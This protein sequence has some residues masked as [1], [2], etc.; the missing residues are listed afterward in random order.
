MQNPFTTTLSQFIYLFSLFF[1]SS[2]TFAS[3]TVFPEPLTPVI[4]YTDSDG[5]SYT[6]FSNISSVFLAVYRYIPEFC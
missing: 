1:N 2:S 4:L 5:F 3:I 6:K